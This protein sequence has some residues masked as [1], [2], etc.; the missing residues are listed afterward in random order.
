MTT[1]ELIEYPFLDK[2]F[3]EFIKPEYGSNFKE[4]FKNFANIIASDIDSASVNINCECTVK[5]TSYIILYKL[6]T[7]SFLITFLNNNTDGNKI[8]ED[9]KTKVEQVNYMAI[10]YGGR[11]AKTSINNWRNF[12]AQIEAENGFYK[13]FSIVKEG[14]DILVFFL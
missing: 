9:L 5:I 8:L 6:E 4:A 2:L 10:P 7:V 12:H 11:I 1:Q 14:D 13:S 3:L